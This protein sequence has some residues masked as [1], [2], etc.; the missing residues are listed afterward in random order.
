MT[1]ISVTLEEVR[2]AEENRHELTYYQERGRHIQDKYRDYCAHIL[3]KVDEL[4][5]EDKDP[6]PFICVKGSSDLEH[7]VE[8][9]SEWPVVDVRVFRALLEYCSSYG[10][11]NTSRMIRFDDR[12]VLQMERRDLNGVCAVLGNCRSLYLM[13]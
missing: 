1:E 2:R 3:I 8:G 6:L 12:I 9:V 10:H 11:Q 13:R 7:L 5:I 4:Y